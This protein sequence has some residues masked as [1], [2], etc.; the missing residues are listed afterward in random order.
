MILFTNTFN[1]A[2]LASIIS[3][4]KNSFSLSLSRSLEDMPESVETRFRELSAQLGLDY[5][6]MCVKD[7]RNCPW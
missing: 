1:I 7:N 6:A 5:D 2:Q 3:V 4:K